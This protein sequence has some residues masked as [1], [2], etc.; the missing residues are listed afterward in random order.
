VYDYMTAVEE[1]WSAIGAV[2]RHEV[3][4]ATTALSDRAHRI[5]RRT[6]AAVER[7]DER[8]S[9]RIDRIRVAPERRL[10]AAERAVAVDHDRLVRRAPGLLTAADRELDLAEARLAVLDPVT[11]LRRGWSITRDASGRAV[12]SADRLTPG[13]LLVTQLA[14][15]TV[16][17]RVEHPDQPDQLADPPSV[18][19]PE[20]QP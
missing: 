19:A 15:G 7:A 17:S 9:T 8:L 4:V 12:R 3:S 11:L 20:G 5:A 14:D 13:E 18:P 2:A 16:T 10:A 6:H 1:R